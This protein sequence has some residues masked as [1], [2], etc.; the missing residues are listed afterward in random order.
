MIKGIV[1][2]LD[3]VIVSTDHYHYLAWKSIADEEKIPFDEEA[4]NRL[5]GVSRMASL[6]IIL[7][8]AKKTYTPEEK[9]KL[10]EKKNEIYRSLLAKMSPKDV[11][12]ENLET[13]KE[14]RAKG[15]KTAIGSSSKNAPF[16]LEK[17]G[18]DKAFDYIVDGSM[19]SHSKPDPEVFLKAA[20]GLGLKPEECLVTEDAYAGV[21]AAK[22][23]GFLAVGIG[24]ASKDPETD[25]P[26]KSL[27]DIFE[28]I[29]KKNT[30]RIQI[31]HLY[32]TY[33]NG[34]EATKDFSLDVYDQEFVVFVGPS[35]CGKSTVL[36]MI[37]GL[38]DVTSGSI[39]LDGEDITDKESSKRDL[40]MVFQNYALYPH[41]SVRKNIAFPLNV[42]SVPFKHFL[43][44]KY[45]KARKEEID[46]K[47]NEAAEIIG[48]TEYL[49][50]KPENL[51]GGQRQR[52]ALGRAIVRNPKAFLLDEP[53]SNLDAKM[54]VSMRSEI[55][56][57][58]ERLKAIFIYVTHDQ[59]EAMTM[60]SKIVVLKEG[61]IQQV[62]TPED[63]F[64]N[65]VNTFVAGFIGT[66][67]MNFL[68]GIV[69]RSNG[70]YVISI[71]GQKEK[72][73]LPVERMKNFND[74]HCNEKLIVGVRPKAISIKGDL[75]Y[76]PKHCFDGKISLFEQL[77]EET[78]VYLDYEGMKDE[79]I[80]ST[81]G[82]GR[83]HKGENI[84]FS[85]DLSSLCL[86]DETT[87]ASLL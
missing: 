32:K 71:M 53:L 13:I 2:D 31:S 67:Q 65:P 37:A 34:V 38:E 36:R 45:R 28:V 9:A 80:A 26:I 1:F 86:F 3:G 72:I 12:P 17:I 43:D 76:D 69:S 10:A 62:G 11:D 83:F 42:S 87:G 74:K 6:D 77:G 78:I 49:D 52:V 8:K 63:I 21:E 58:H 60:G 4:N 35:G 82:L 19:I 44:F 25:Y 48:L 51:S 55:S 29:K 40:A 68:S 61:S 7:E 50:R 5:R 64:L 73:A 59:T 30:P 84:S 47:V 39:T 70:K 18:L 57:L 24:D 54:R 20:A 75:S 14:L 41:L 85:I 33:P 79:L 15:L 81:T 56:H 46:K 23:G 16:I 66:P 27:K 22:N